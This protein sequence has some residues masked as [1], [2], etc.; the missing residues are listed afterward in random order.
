MAVY[1]LL[2]EVLLYPE[3]LAGT[4]RVNPDFFY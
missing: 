3:C 4:A 2:A 1:P